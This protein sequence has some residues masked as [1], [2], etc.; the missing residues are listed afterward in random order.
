M[1]TVCHQAEKCRGL[2]LQHMGL[3]GVLLF[4]RYLV[5][6]GNLAEATVAQHP[7]SHCRVPSIWYSREGKM[8]RKAFNPRNYFACTTLKLFYVCL[9]PPFFSPQQASLA[10]FTVST[11]LPTEDQE[12]FWSAQ[13]TRRETFHHHSEAQRTS[14]TY[15][16]VSKPWP[17]REQFCNLLDTDLCQGQMFCEGVR[18]LKGAEDTSLVLLFASGCVIQ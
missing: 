4:V 5:V 3:A 16:L 12:H 13:R 2:L 8:K 14:W 7:L 15:I 9:S 6:W 1:V 18:T 11:R 10:K 17:C